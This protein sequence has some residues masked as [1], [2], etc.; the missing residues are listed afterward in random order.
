MHLLSCYL[1][2]YIDSTSRP[3]L[4]PNSLVV[5]FLACGSLQGFDDDNSSTTTTTTSV[6]MDSDRNYE[7]PEDYTYH[8]PLI[9]PIKPPY[10][11]AV[12]LR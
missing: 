11:K 7:L 1:I 10:E 12:K 2:N 5:P 8:E 6:T 3:R 4:G 9:S